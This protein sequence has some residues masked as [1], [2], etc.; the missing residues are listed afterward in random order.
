MAKAMTDGDDEGMGFDRA[1]PRAWASDRDVDLSDPPHVEGGGDLW[2]DFRVGA[3]RVNQVNTAEETAHLKV[4]VSC[5]RTSSPSVV[6]V[7]TNLAR[8]SHTTRLCTLTRAYRMCFSCT[9]HLE[10]LCVICEM[11]MHTNDAVSST[12]RT[13]LLNSSP[14]R[15]SIMCTVRTQAFVALY[16][17]DPRMVGW[18]GVLPDN[19]W[20][21][22]CNCRNGIRADMDVDDHEVRVARNACMC[23]SM[24]AFMHAY[25]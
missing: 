13:Q 25:S 15:L 16:W 5:M 21:P 7:H 6:C 4:Y 23:P 24:Q 19:L 11:H 8:S 1:T 10:A 12:M 17:T 14:P 20:G 2:V 9:M 22:W 3:S 18:E